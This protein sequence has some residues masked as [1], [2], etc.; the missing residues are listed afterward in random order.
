MLWRC[1][2]LTGG[3]PMWFWHRHWDWVW[4]RLLWWWCG[5]VGLLALLSGHWLWLGWLLELLLRWWWLWLLW[6]GAGLCPLRRRS[7]SG[8]LV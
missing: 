8:V 1:L 3:Y 6:L 5:L 4:D 2:M 7:W